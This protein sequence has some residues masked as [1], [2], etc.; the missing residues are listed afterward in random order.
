MSAPTRE[1]T[2]GW[3]FT[4]ALLVWLAVEVL[5][6]YWIMPLPGSQRGGTIDAAYGLDRWIWVIRGVAGLALLWALARLL[7]R[8]RWP[9][10]IASL[11]GLSL[12]GL[13][14]FQT[15]GP[16]SADVMFRQPTRLS[17]AVAGQGSVAP[18]ALVVGVALTDASGGSQARAYP[19]QF[20]GYHHQVRDVVAGHPV[21]VTYC[22]VCRTGRVW[23][24]VVEGT[25][26][27]FRLVGMDHWNA[28]FEDSRTGSWWR[29]ANGEAITGPLEGQRLAEIPSQQMTWA[30]W[31]ARHPE[32]DVMQPDPEFA[33]AYAHMVGFA[34]G[35][36]PGS[37]TGRDPASWQRKSWVVGVVVGDAARAFDWNELVRERIL[38]DRVGDQPVILLL[39]ADGASFR[40]FASALEL[41]PTENP[42]RFRDRT[43]G[44]LWD[45][46]GLALD[47]P[48]AGTRWATVPAYQEFWHS[49]QDFH[50]GTTARGR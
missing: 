21:M 29:Q 7:V 46:S 4:L 33:E 18:E 1:R 27:T 9:A 14:A 35:T 10:R 17:F 47:G 42:S 8:G 12:L 41:E 24:P 31:S 36:K 39:G 25:V 11:L 44:G 15:N 16:M 32:S 28:M 22:T 19:I 48:Q 13:V 34:E 49:W 6:V 40:V 38:R 20:I 2:A 50:P 23:S 26:E 37:L 43:S 5:R 45:E 30:A 3:I